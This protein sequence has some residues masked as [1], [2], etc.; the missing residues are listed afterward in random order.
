MYSEKRLIKALKSLE[1]LFVQQAGSNKSSHLT[2]S[3][4]SAKNQTGAII[5]FIQADDISAAL[6]AWRALAY[7]TDDSIGPSEKFLEKYEPI[8]QKVVNAGLQ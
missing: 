5:K 1:E 4:I 6:N 2:N 7:F 8:K 3:F